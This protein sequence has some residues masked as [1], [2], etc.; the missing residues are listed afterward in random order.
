MQPIPDGSWLDGSLALI[1]RVK[2]AVVDGDLSV[3]ASSQAFALALQG[4]AKKTDIVEAQ[5]VGLQT[6]VR[7]VQ[8]ICE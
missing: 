8:K 2:Q 7:G 3:P 1:E 4:Q 5:L 6:W